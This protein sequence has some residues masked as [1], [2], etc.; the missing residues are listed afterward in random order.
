MKRRFFTL[1]GAVATS[2][3]FSTFAQ[4]SET[5]DVSA[6][7]GAISSVQSAMISILTPL[8]TAVVAIVLAGVAIW[9]IPRVVG[10]LK[11]AFQ[12]GK[13]RS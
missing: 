6:A 9:A 7:T 1:V 2:L 3:P 11:G 12:S 5:V 8:G 13:G 4:S 10:S